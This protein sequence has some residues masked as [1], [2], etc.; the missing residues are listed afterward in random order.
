MCENGN[1][2]SNLNDWIVHVDVDVN[3]D[4]ELAE[5]GEKEREELKDDVDGF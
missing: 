5:I 3:V 2:A 1:L 4:V